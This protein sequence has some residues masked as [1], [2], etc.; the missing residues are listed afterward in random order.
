MI[1]NRGIILLMTLASAALFSTGCSIFQPQVSPQLTAEVTAAA[2]GSQ[3]AEPGSMI[4]EIRPD[5]SEPKRTE[6]ELT[7]PL[8]VQDAME[9]TG[10]SKK[11]RRCFVDLLRPLPD[12]RLHRMSLEFDRDNK[13]VPPEFDYAV[14]PGDRL[15][16]TEDTSNLVDDAMNAAMKPFGGAQRLKGKTA[17]GGRYR[18][19]G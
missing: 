13:R 2:D 6:V 14:L 11:F 17:S 1:T 3:P 9:K 15:V 10:A 12:G 16:I 19:G 5:G 18:V 8:H 4:V 7:E